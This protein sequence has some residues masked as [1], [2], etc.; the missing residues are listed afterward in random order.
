MRGLC[1]SIFWKKN[2]CDNVSENFFSYSKDSFFSK[3]IH[4][5]SFMAIPLLLLQQLEV[6]FKSLSDRKDAKHLRQEQK[7][8][9]FTF[10]VPPTRGVQSQAS[11]AAMVS[12]QLQSCKQPSSLLLKSQVKVVGMASFQSQSLKEFQVQL[13][14][15]MKA[16]CQRYPGVAH[17]HTSYVNF[18]GSLYTECVH[19]IMRASI[20]SC[21]DYEQPI[22]AHND[23]RYGYFCTAND[24]HNALRILTTALSLGQL[25]WEPDFIII[26]SEHSDR[27]T[28]LTILLKELCQIKNAKSVKN[29]ALALLGALLILTA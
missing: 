17:V 8:S 15:Y 25:E 16:I 24:M 12:V 13:S 11:A 3:F 5:A 21:L 7:S 22:T 20:A 1:Y 19:A 27:Q 18:G 10:V 26:E 4:C 14:Q 9:I 23:G 2:K 28:Q 29:L 6:Q